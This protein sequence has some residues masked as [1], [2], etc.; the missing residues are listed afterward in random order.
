MKERERE[1]ER[2][3]KRE[4][5]KEKKR[6]AEIAEDGKTCAGKIE[7]SRLNLSDDDRRA[8]MWEN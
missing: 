8:I 7:S 5:E 3:R 6:R 1:R 4:R 2:E